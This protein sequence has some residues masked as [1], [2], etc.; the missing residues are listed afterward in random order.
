MKKE[1]DTPSVEFVEFES[2]VTTDGSTQQTHDGSETSCS[3]TSYLGSDWTK[4]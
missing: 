1:Y 4:T 3:C 2:V